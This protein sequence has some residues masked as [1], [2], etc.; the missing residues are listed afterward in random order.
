MQFPNAY[1]G[2]KKIRTAEIL[3]LI[4]AL[5]LLIM[6][7]LGIVALASGSVGGALASVA[8]MGIFGIGAGVLG[9]IAFILCIVGLSAA[10]KDESQFKSALIAVLIGLVATVVASFFGDETIKEIGTTVQS[11]ANLISTILVVSGIISLATQLNNDAVAT[12]GKTIL[13]LI[14]CFNVLALIADIVGLFIPGG[15]IV[16]AIIALAAVVL[17]I[18]V[19]IIY[20]GYLK[21]AV[22]MLGKG[23]AVAEAAPAPVEAAVE[24]V[25]ETVEAA[26]EEK[27]E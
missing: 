6:A 12:R 13:K 23:T 27:P 16:G 20:L 3:Q 2:V 19:Y 11:L 9:I 5:C 26:A 8:G 15:Q 21:K 7:I 22:V 25:T 1:T 4:G 24:E 18:I 10:G 17:D 14:V